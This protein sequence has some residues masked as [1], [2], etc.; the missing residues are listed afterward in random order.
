MNIRNKRGY[1]QI[2]CIN[3]NENKERSCQVERNLDKI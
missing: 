1:I 2:H 3:R